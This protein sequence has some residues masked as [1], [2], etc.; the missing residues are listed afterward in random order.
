MHFQE[1]KKAE[2]GGGLRNAPR[3]TINVLRKYWDLTIL[4]LNF[5]DFFHTL[6]SYIFLSLLPPKFNLTSMRFQLLISE[7]HQISIF[8]FLK[9]QKL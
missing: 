6:N 1:E 4:I 3:K 7:A 9:E 2:E 8:S 5:E